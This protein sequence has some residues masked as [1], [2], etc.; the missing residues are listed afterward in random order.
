MTTTTKNTKKVTTKKTVKKEVKNFDFTEIYAKVKSFAVN[1]YNTNNRLVDFKI[2]EIEFN[3]LSHFRKYLL[4]F[5]IAEKQNYILTGITQESYTENLELSKYYLDEIKEKQNKVLTTKSLVVKEKLDSEIKAIQIAILDIDDTL[6]KPILSDSILDTYQSKIDKLTSTIQRS[7]NN[8]NQKIVKKSDVKTISN[9]FDDE[10]YK[11]VF[12]NRILNTKNFEP[13]TLCETFESFI[14]SV[15]LNKGNNELNKF[16]EFT[17]LQ[18]FVSSSSPFYKVLFDRV[19]NS[20][21]I[22]Y[23]SQLKFSLANFKLIDSK[24]YISKNLKAI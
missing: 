3:S 12:K 19:I 8:F 24:V 9:L 1:D 5:L 21:K 20:D 14:N 6:K 2:S 7:T 15:T 16:G 17:S 23:G 11:E 4:S 13:S 10:K 18:I 22:R